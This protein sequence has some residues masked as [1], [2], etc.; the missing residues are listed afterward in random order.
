[1]EIR[2]K[3][4]RYMWRLYIYSISIISFEIPFSIRRFEANVDT[5]RLKSH[6]PLRYQIS[7]E[8][9]ARFF[10]WFSKLSISASSFRM[11]MKTVRFFWSIRKK[12]SSEYN[13]SSNTLMFRIYVEQWAYSQWNDLIYV[14]IA[15]NFPFLLICLNFKREEFLSL[16][17]S[18]IWNLFERFYHLEIYRLNE[19]VKRIFNR[20]DNFFNPF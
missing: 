18:C 9:L 11:E 20:F 15:F 10:F 4:F 14:S 8:D 16:H 17:L 5:I 12:D 7:G 1:M 2:A 19:L 13:L 3:N 6:C